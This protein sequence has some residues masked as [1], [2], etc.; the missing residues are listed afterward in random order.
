MKKAFTIGALALACSFAYGADLV[1]GRSKL[2]IAG[3]EVYLNHDSTNITRAVNCSGV[4]VKNTIEDVACPAGTQGSKKIKKRY[5]GPNVE[6]FKCTDTGSYSRVEDGEIVENTCNALCQPKK[7][8]FEVLSKQDPSTKKACYHGL[9]GSILVKKRWSISGTPTAK[10]LSAGYYIPASDCA[11]IQT[12]IQDIQEVSDCGR[13][14]R[15]PER[16]YNILNINKDKFPKEL[17]IEVSRLGNTPKDNN[18]GLTPFYATAD[19]SFEFNKSMQDYYGYI[20]RNKDKIQSAHIEIVKANIP[21]MFAYVDRF[22]YS[23]PYAEFYQSIKDSYSPTTPSCKGMSIDTG[24]Y[25][26][27]EGEAEVTCA[28]NL[29]YSFSQAN[30]HNYNKL[31]DF[32]SQARRGLVPLDVDVLPPNREQV[33]FDYAIYDKSGNLRH[34]TTPLLPNNYLIYNI[35]VKFQ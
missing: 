5:Y 9:K 20:Q 30:Q 17:K 14:L 21:F 18:Y 1:Q 32:T 29:R 10:D 4:V 8:F 35:I 19:T 3:H 2:N 15:E 31:I 16:D 22:V 28:G 24:K 11:S 7:H 26:R 34:G 27:N 12:S 6:S 13:V 25:A 33:R 23:N